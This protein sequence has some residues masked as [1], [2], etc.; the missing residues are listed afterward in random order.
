M[1]FIWPVTKKVGIYVARYESKL[2]SRLLYML[3]F[4]TMNT[5]PPAEE[6]EEEEEEEEQEE[7]EEDLHG[8][9]SGIVINHTTPFSLSPYS[10]LHFSFLIIVIVNSNLHWLQLPFIA[11]AYLN[12]LC[13]AIILISEYLSYFDCW[14]LTWF[15]LYY[16][17]NWISSDQ[18]RSERSPQ[19]IYPR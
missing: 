15:A 2:R 9:L 19:L 11:I 16:P 8:A 10:P 3:P 14:F 7:E 13:L 12:L 6:E 18:N 17:A 4:K 5:T 1:E